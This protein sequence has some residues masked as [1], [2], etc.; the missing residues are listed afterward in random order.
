MGPAGNGAETLKVTTKGRA[1]AWPVDGET[2][3]DPL[4]CTAAALGAGR[5][6]EDGEDDAESHMTMSLVMRTRG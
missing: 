5:E 6:E 2:P 4:T 1:N 3:R